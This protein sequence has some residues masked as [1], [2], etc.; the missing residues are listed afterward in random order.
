[1]DELYVTDKL[2]HNPDNVKELG[3]NIENLTMKKVDLSLGE[4]D[5]L[6]EVFRLFK[7]TSLD[8]NN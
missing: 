6:L 2:E 3:H 7:K 1:M 5:L 8:V 4:R